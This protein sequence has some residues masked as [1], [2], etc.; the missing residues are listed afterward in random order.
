MFVATRALFVATKALFATANQK[1]KKRRC[2][3][4][5]V[6]KDPSPR[7]ISRSPKTYTTHIIHLEDLYRRGYVLGFGRRMRDDQIGPLGVEV[8]SLREETLPKVSLLLFLTLGPEKRL[9]SSRSKKEP[10][11]FGEGLKTQH[12]FIQ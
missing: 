1:S 12:I 7:Q 2:Y 6:V 8:W 4:F 10:G 5:T 3:R 9:E 11:I